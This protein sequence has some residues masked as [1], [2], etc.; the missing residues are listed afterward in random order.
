[1]IRQAFQPNSNDMKKKPETSK[2][3]D[4]TMHNIYGQNEH[5]KTALQY[6]YF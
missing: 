6:L 1:M 3:D 5:R 4:K 2:E